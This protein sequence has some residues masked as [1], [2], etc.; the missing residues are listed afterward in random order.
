MIITDCSACYCP[1]GTVLPTFAIYIIGITIPTLLFT[2]VV[3]AVLL[4]KTKR[5]KDSEHSIF[6]KTRISVSKYERQLSENSQRMILRN[7]NNDDTVQLNLNEHLHDNDEVDRN[8]TNAVEASN[9]IEPNAQQI[10]VKRQPKVPLF[11]QMPREEINKICEAV[12]S[13]NRIKEATSLSDLDK[14]VND[15]KED[16]KEKKYKIY[17]MCASTPELDT[18]DD[19]EPIQKLPVYDPNSKES[20]LRDEMKAMF[21]QDDFKAKFNQGKI[22]LKESEDEMKPQDGIKFEDEIKSKVVEEETKTKKQEHITLKPKQCEIKSIEIN[23][24]IIPK[25]NQSELKSKCNSLSGDVT[26]PADQDIFQDEI[27][28]CPPTRPRNESQDL[29]SSPN[30][31]IYDF[32]PSPKP[33]GELYDFPP[34]PQPHNEIYE[35]PPASRNRN[36]IVRDDDATGYLF[37]ISDSNKA[38]SDDPQYTNAKSVSDLSD[39]G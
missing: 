3:L 19:L 26:K 2:T 24:D 11:P 20:K 32:P 10:K 27:Y 31:E 38:L 6:G 23:N 17:D 14:I 9:V 21:N 15:A 35:C 12:L 18:F 4:Y 1:C 8:D 25:F 37:P 13:R 22:K 28:D 34:S 39:K 29:P 33:S 7:S 16:A 30:D 36:I 5:I